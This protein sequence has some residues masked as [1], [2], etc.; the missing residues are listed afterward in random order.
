MEIKTFTQ[1]T[2]KSVTNDINKALDAVSRQY[3]LNLSLGTVSFTDTKFTT[4]LTAEV[5]DL[6][7]LSY[8]YEE[9]LLELGL[10]SDL[11]GRVLESDGKTYTVTGLNMRSEY[12]VLWERSDGRR[13]KAAVGLV[14][15]ALGNAD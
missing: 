3:G 14:Q 10:P 5:G 9:D 8:A 15:R 1:E 7:I 11:I 12:P 6:E 4:R 13:Y 2:V